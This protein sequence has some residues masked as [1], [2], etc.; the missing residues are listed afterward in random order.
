MISG[1]TPKDSTDVAMATK[2]FWRYVLGIEAYGGSEGEELGIYR[3]CSTRSDILDPK[4]LCF[5]PRQSAR[6]SSAQCPGGRFRPKV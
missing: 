4:L 1:S 2:Y 3:D 5:L 6:I